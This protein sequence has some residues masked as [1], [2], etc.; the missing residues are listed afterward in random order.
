[1]KTKMAILLF[2]QL[3]LLQAV[4]AQKSNE[5]LI[6][7]LFSSEEF[8]NGIRAFIEE[9]GGVDTS[10]RVVN[11]IDTFMYGRLPE[12]FIENNA[13]SIF[14][15]YKELITD[16]YY[17]EFYPIEKEKIQSY[18]EDLL[19]YKFDRIEFRVHIRESDG[20][21]YEIYD[22]IINGKNTRTITIVFVK[23][24]QLLGW[25]DIKWVD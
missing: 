6:D 5:E 22:F 24:L 3:F 2:T 19:K 20:N 25:E 12:I 11:R 14:D 9:I 17:E 10:Y 18:Y 7:S 4:R 1:M 21:R 8:I 16:F 15:C 13:Y 23:G